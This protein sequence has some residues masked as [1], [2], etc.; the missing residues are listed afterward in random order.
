MAEDAER[1]EGR[2]LREDG[3]M[4]VVCI[5]KVS[6]NNKLLFRILLIARSQ[7]C[8]DVKLVDNGKSYG[9]KIYSLLNPA[10]R[11]PGPA[12]S[13]LQSAFVNVRP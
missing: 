8:E 11:A 2:K 5:E 10:L 1:E 6:F 3:R 12:L 7:E 9:A 13:Q 4:E